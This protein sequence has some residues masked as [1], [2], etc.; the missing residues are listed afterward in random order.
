[1]SNKPVAVF[2]ASPLILCALCGMLGQ[3][4]YAPRLSAQTWELPQGM[5]Y[6]S[7]SQA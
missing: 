4:L 3:S 6:N 1:M 2:A 7:D 5:D